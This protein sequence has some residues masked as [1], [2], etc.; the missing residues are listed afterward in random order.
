MTS[1]EVFVGEAGRDRL[2]GRAHFTRGRR[3]VS[4]TFVYDP[5]YLVDG[6]MNID[7]ALLLTSG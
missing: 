1:V 7:P 6:G 5:S 3:E 2:V 4:T